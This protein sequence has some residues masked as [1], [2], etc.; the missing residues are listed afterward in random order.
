MAKSNGYTVTQ[1]VNKIAELL[2]NGY[3]RW[4]IVQ[5]SAT[6]WKICER[7]VDT[8][9]QRATELIE[10]SVKRRIGFEFAKAIRRLEDLYKKAMSK[11]DLKT[12][13]NVNRELSAL[14]GLY[15]LSKDVSEIRMEEELERIE[16]LDSYLPD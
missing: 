14:Q 4:D 10:L 12:A 1:R 11:G 8:Y 2:L 15:L 13:L 3:S 6:N 16:N 7:Q 5:Y 9:L